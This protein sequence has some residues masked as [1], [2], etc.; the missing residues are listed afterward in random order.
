MK[1]HAHFP[2]RP[3]NSLW[4]RVADMGSNFLGTFRITGGSAKRSLHTIPPSQKCS[5]LPVVAPPHIEGG[6]FCASGLE[7]LERILEAMPRKTTGLELA[8]CVRTKQQS[9]HRRD[10]EIPELSGFWFSHGRLHGKVDLRRE[11]KR[12]WF[13]VYANE[14]GY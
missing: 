3:S 12:G 1:M 8:P 6:L 2:H 9:T 7:G 14:A 13:E 5:S 11:P 10:N 4:R